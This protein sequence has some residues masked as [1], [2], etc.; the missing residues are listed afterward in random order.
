MSTVQERRDANRMAQAMIRGDELKVLD[1]L[2]AIRRRRGID[3]A[4]AAERRADSVAQGRKR[5][6]LAPGH[7]DLDWF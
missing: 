6:H 2:D 4:D 7:P 5:G 3:A 1:I